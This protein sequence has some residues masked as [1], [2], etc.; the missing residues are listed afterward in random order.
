MV[1][2]AFLRLCEKIRLREESSQ[3]VVLT[4]D[5]IKLKPEK[6]KNKNNATSLA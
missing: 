2:N 5:L 4:I 6:N 1:V 3:I